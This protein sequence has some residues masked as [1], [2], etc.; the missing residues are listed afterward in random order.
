V[1]LAVDRGGRLALRDVQ[2]EQAR[3]ERA[4]DRAGG[5]QHRLGEARAV[6]GDEDPR[7]AHGRPA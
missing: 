1:R 6:E 4:R 2:E 7:E 3:A 5:G